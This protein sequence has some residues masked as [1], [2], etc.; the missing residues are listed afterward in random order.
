MR[1]ETVQQNVSAGQPDAKPLRLRQGDVIRAAVVSADGEAVTLKSEDG[2]VFRARLEAGELHANDTVELMVSQGRQDRLVLRVVFVEPG[3]GAPTAAGTN[4]AAAVSAAARRAAPEALLAAFA[5]MSYTPGAKQLALASAMLRDFPVDAKTAAFFAVNDI[6]A[7]AQKAAA[8]AAIAKGERLGESLYAL[9]KQ[10]A[11]GQAPQNGSAVPAGASAA[12][13]ANAQAETAITIMPAA[14]V[15]T[16]ETAVPAANAQTEAAPA[17]AGETPRGAEPPVHATRGAAVLPAGTDT[18]KNFPS[19]PAAAEPA[20]AR[21]GA[22]HAPAGNTEALVL[23]EGNQENT[24]LAGGLQASPHRETTAGNPGVS[25]EGPE[26]A[27]PFAEKAQASSHAAA[28][29][30]EHG[31][32]NTAA[33]TPVPSGAAKE[34]APEKTLAKAY[35]KDTQETATI[36]RD[37]IGDNGTVKEQAQQVPAAALPE[38]EGNPPRGGVPAAP[39]AFRTQTQGPAQGQDV[40]APLKETEG[41]DIAGKLLGLFLEGEGLTA[42]MLKKAVKETPQKLAELQKMLENTDSTLQR[43]LSAKLEE[44]TAQAKLPEDITRFA[45]AQIPI[46]QAGYGTAELYV[47]RRNRKGAQ[48]DPGNACI[49][50]GLSTENLGRVEALIRIENRNIFIGMQ[51][52]NEAAI[53]LFGEKTA[54]LYKSLGRMRYALSEL[55]VSP[56]GEPTTPANAEETL[57]SLAQRAGASVDVKI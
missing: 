31:A 10:A 52:E 33:G 38:K 25:G 51:V 39:G 45:F 29:P 53:P 32:E 44:L 20:A 12:P 2:Q 6:P 48:L 18:A 46:R 21:E 22:A 23:F 34:T 14:N 37:R 1:I 49:A 11:D 9:A 3:S 41:R 8:F 40:P 19:G 24:V 28:L 13:A 27:A 56:L 54:E 5:Q 43:H 57:A 7:D 17:M 47:Y 26:S 50:L 35:P 30:R 16:E 55:K 4:D 36:G 15:Q 42:Q